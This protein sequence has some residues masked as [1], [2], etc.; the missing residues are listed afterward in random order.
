[1]DAGSGKRKKQLDIKF[2]NENLTIHDE[3]KVVVKNAFTFVKGGQEIG[4]VD[5]EYD[6]SNLPPQLHL[7]ALN[8]INKGTKV[9][10]NI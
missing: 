3:P 2:D 1:M 10:V 4:H 7:L 5:A 9:Y 8:C 6:F